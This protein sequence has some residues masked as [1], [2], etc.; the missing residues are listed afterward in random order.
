MS[1]YSFKGNNPNHEVMVGWDPPLN[2]YF[3][4]VLDVSKNEDDNGRDLLWIGCTPNEIHDLET[5][6]RELAPYARVSEVTLARMY[7][8]A[9]R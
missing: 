3:A 1:N 7:S 4:H 9:N 5:I 8:D 6:T 2:T